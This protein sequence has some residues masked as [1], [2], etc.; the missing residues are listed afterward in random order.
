[1]ANDQSSRALL[2]GHR[3]PAASKI[4][5]QRLQP[6]LPK[7]MSF[8]TYWCRYLLQFPGVFPPTSSSELMKATN[9]QV[10]RRLEG[11]SARARSFRL[12][13]ERST[14]ASGTRVPSRLFHPP[15]SL[16]SMDGQEATKPSGSSSA[17]ARRSTT[18]FQ[19]SPDSL[20]FLLL[21]LVDSFAF[22]QRAF[23]ICFFF[24]LRPYVR[25]VL[26]S[27]DSGSSCVLASMT[28]P[29]LAHRNVTRDIPA[30]PS[31][32]RCMYSSTDV[33]RNNHFLIVSRWKALLLSTRRVRTVTSMS[34][35]LR[36]ILSYLNS[37]SL[38]FPRVSSNSERTKKRCTSE[39]IPVFFL[40]LDAACL[41]TQVRGVLESLTKVSLV[42]LLRIR[43][44]CQMLKYGEFQMCKKS[45][46][47]RLKDETRPVLE[48]SRQND[49]ALQSCQILRTERRLEHWSGPGL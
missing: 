25:A 32:C 13:C 8:V 33:D 38:F 15:P 26:V 31:Y 42:D 17:R 43:S 35:L 5:S 36:A 12:T 24:V 19:V 34:L 2:D 29:S 37:S 45:G 21:D 41:A 1:M 20:F 14:S 3:I 6:D 9:K 11:Q 28:S 44:A 40:A 7:T 48:R 23:Y 18:L 47:F 10:Y 4:S 49:V 16:L 22:A 46:K 30:F 27:S 39:Q